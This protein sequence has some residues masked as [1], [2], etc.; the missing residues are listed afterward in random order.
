ML[1]DMPNNQLHIGSIGSQFFNRYG[2]NLKPAELGFNKT[3]ELIVALSNT[4]E[5]NFPLSLKKIINAI[6]ANVCSYVE[7]SFDQKISGI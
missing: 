5:V 4:F 6:A 3:R 2:K 7:L 1:D